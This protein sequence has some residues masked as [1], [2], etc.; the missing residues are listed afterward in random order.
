MTDT[1]PYVYMY[2]YDLHEKYACV[3]EKYISEI[4]EARIFT[5]IRRVECEIN[6]KSHLLLTISNRER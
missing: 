3:P 4:Y 1:G 6:P 2:A 5:K